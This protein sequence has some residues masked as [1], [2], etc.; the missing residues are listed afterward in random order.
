M[1]KFLLRISF[2]CAGVLSFIAVALSSIMPKK[3]TVFLLLVVYFVVFFSS[4]SVFPNTKNYVSYTFFSLVFLSAD[5]K[6][7]AYVWITIFSA[8]FSE[9]FWFVLVLFLISFLRFESKNMVVDWDVVEDIEFKSLC[10][11]I[12]AAIKLLKVLFPIILANHLAL[13]HAYKALSVHEFNYWRE[14]YQQLYCH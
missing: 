11:G 2:C 5:I 4:Q 13:I 8:N 12:Y 9:L 14:F 3:R 6:I 7:R 1:C 10:V